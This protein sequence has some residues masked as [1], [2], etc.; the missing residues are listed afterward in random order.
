MIQPM[1]SSV[2]DMLNMHRTETLGQDGFGQDGRKK[3]MLG[4]I[5]SLELVLKSMQNQLEIDHQMI[6]QHDRQLAEAALE[7]RLQKEKLTLLE[8]ELQLQ[9]SKRFGHS[10][11]RWTPDE[12]IQADLFDEIEK[13]IA[14]ANPD[15]DDD[16]VP[17]TAASVEFPPHRR[18]QRKQQPNRPDAPAKGRKPLPAHL[19]R[20]EKRLELPKAELVCDCCGKDL[21]LIGEETSE[22]LCTAPV[23]HYVERTIRPK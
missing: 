18:K 10:T 9:I 23:K 15:Q 2:I 3:S 21:V 14:E 13:A 19:E 22:G 11:E 4:T 12:K 1:D 7:N 17:D 8:N 5:D 20:R 6:V 16:K